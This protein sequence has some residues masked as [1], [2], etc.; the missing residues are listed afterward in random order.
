MAPISCHKQW[1]C[2]CGHDLCQPPALEESV[3]FWHGHG[4]C[5]RLLHLH[6]LPAAH[7]LNMHMLCS[8]V[9]W[10]FATFIFRLGVS[11]ARKQPFKGD[12]IVIPWCKHHLFVFLRIRWAKCQ[13]YLSRNLARIFAETTAFEFTSIRTTVWDGKDSYMWFEFWTIAFAKESALPFQ[14]LIISLDW[15]KR[16]S[17]GKPH[18]SWEKPYK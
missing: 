8:M 17:A 11:R 1:C 2:R 6:L 9:Q 14:H 13:V 5:L 4:P 12:Y 3:Q 18:I 7:G 16:N 15:F 10:R